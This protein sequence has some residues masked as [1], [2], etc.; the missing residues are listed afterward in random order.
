LRL[1]ATYRHDLKIKASD[2]GRVMKT[3]AAFAKG[4]LELEGQLTPI[5]ASLVTVEAKN[6]SLL[7]YSD[8]AAVKEDLD[9]CKHHLNDIQR[10]SISDEFVEEWAKDCPA[11]IRQAI[12]QIREPLK[13]LMRMHVLIGQLCAQLHRIVEM[14]V[15]PIADEPKTGDDSKDINIESR[16]V[17]RSASEDLTKKLY[18]GETYALM[19]DRWEKLNKDFFNQKEK[20]FDLSKVPD[21][22]DMI[23]YDILHNS[24]AELEGM[25]ELYEGIRAFENTLV[26][27]EYGA[28]K[29]EKK[30]I[31]SK[32]CGALLEKIKYD[33]KVSRSDTTHDMRY[34]LDHSHAEDLEINSLGRVVRTRLYFTSESHMHT[35]L[36]VLRHVK[37]K[38]E[39]GKEIRAISSEGLKIIEDVPELSYLT[40]IVIRL[41]EDREDHTKFRCE[42]S[43]SPGSTTDIFTDKSPTVAPYKTINGNISCDDLIACLTQAVVIGKELPPE[44]ADKTVK[45]EFLDTSTSV[46]TA[47]HDLHL[48]A[49]PYTHGGEDSKTNFSKKAQDGSLNEDGD[50]PLRAVPNNFEDDDFREVSHI[51]TSPRRDKSSSNSTNSSTSS[52]IRGLITESPIK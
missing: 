36:N 7:D 48:T 28:N 14:E 30:L 24:N 52:P 27:Q 46:S 19:L 15:I 25:R 42:I 18:L 20:R 31:G 32:V 13:C 49:Q 34:M 10:K 39:N 37:V 33:L 23:R 5:I 22:Y 4:L 26:P 8:N 16:S 47:D 44:E 17:E 35:L 41:F 43:F 1:H 11:S 9:D 3:A 21:V 38:K 29:A 51:N 12:N 6:K 45:A 40:Q 50:A 2:E